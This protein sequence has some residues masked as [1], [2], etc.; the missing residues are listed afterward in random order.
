MPER[1]RAFEAAIAAS[2]VLTY[3]V[4]VDVMNEHPWLEFIPRAE[5][6][7]GKRRWKEKHKPHPSSLY[8]QV[9]DV[10]EKVSNAVIALEGLIQRHSHPAASAPAQ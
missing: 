4:V 1:L 9:N 2:D 7:K 10:V 6:E 8:L 5:F 3:H